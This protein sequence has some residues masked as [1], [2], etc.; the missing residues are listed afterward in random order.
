MPKMRPPDTRQIRKKGIGEHRRIWCEKQHSFFCGSRKR[1]PAPIFYEYSSV[2]QLVEQ[3]AVNRLVAG[4]SPVGGAGES[5]NN[6]IDTGSA[7]QAP[8]ERKKK[9]EKFERTNIEKWTNDLVREKQILTFPSLV[10]WTGDSACLKSRRDWSDTNTR[11]C[12]DN[13]C[14]GV[15]RLAAGIAIPAVPKRARRNKNRAVSSLLA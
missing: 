11:H 13:R 14:Y 8:A 2:A 1:E 15:V 5:H 4:S 7:E 6:K 12:I 3:A 9:Q 10:S